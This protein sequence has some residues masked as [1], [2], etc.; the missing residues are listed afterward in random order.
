MVVK[1]IYSIYTTKIL[2]FLDEDIV[3]WKCPWFFTD[4]IH[5][6]ATKHYYT[7]FNAF[8][9]RL[10]MH[11]NGYGDVR[12]TTFDGARKFGGWPRAGK[13][14]NITK[15]SVYDVY[16]RD[17]KGRPVRDADGNKVVLGTKAYA[18]AFKVWNVEEIDGIELP[19]LPEPKKETPEN[20]TSF[21]YNYIRREGVTLNF[22]ESDRAF[23]KPST[24][25]IVLPPES[26][27]RS[28][29]A[30][31]STLYHESAHSTGH[32][33]RLNRADDLGEA[34]SFGDTSYAREELVAEFCSSFL[35]AHAGI[36]TEDEMKQRASY[37]A[38]WKEAIIDDPKCVILGAN[39]G[40]KAAE[41]ILEK[42][43]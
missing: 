37:I 39:R 40:A 13:W 7:G 34:I 35:C 28:P 10:H 17:H 16:E 14:T 5:N 27:F 12:Y 38:S 33:S 15:Y 22:S 4:G 19:P 20:Y 26:M 9:L 3:P 2:E 30:F 21:V 32:K 25:T 11:I 31:A 43:E 42:G 29:E 36:V 23:Y 8:W 41:Y 6:P 18:K 1:D 24:D